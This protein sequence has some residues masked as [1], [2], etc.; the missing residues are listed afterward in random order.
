VSTGSVIEF[1]LIGRQHRAGLILG[2]MNR[3]RQIFLDLIHIRPVL[4]LDCVVFGALLRGEQIEDG[5][6]A[7]LNE[8]ATIPEAVS[9][10]LVDHRP[11]PLHFLALFRSQRLVEL[12]PRA[13]GMRM[14]VAWLRGN[15]LA[16]MSIDSHPHNRT[17]G[18]YDEKR[19]HEQE[20]E[21]VHGF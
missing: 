16:E 10:L 3:I 19:Q 15:L 7:L 14:S 8:Y 9:P 12:P 2:L 18:E 5:L 1:Q 20:F 6:V 4:L 11:D 21:L 17:G 13:H